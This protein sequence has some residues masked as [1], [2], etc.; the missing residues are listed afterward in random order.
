VDLVSQDEYRLVYRLFLGL[1]IVLIFSYFLHLRSLTLRVAEPLP[2]AE[3]RQKITNF[4]A[5]IDVAK[6]GLC[7]AN[8]LPCSWFVDDGLKLL[9]PAAGVGAGF[10]LR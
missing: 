4:G 1:I 10:T 7:W 6:D 5:K 8:P 9:D 2:V 3:V